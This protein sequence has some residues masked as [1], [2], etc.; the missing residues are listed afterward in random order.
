MHNVST[1]ANGGKG[2]PCRTKLKNKNKK[3]K[4]ANA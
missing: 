3:K 2:P 1:Q 4:K